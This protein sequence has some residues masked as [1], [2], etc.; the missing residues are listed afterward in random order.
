MDALAHA[1]N[2]LAYALVP[3]G[4]EDC[5]ECVLRARRVVSHYLHATA[6]ARH[7]IVASP[8]VRETLA[9][10]DEA[11]KQLSQCLAGHGSHLC[12]HCAMEPVKTCLLTMLCHVHT[13]YHLT[14]H[15]IQ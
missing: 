11:Y 12:R 3:V 5:N 10:F 7:R 4:S 6:V 1:V 9:R 13:L 2:G 8:E 14:P 15:F